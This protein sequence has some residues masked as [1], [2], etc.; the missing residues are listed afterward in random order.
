MTKDFVS[1]MDLMPEIFKL[2]KRDITGFFNVRR[3]Y[4]RGDL[5][6]YHIQTTDSGQKQLLFVDGRYDLAQKYEE[7]TGE[8]V[9]D[10]YRKG[11]R[12]HIKNHAPYVL[13]Q[14]YD[15]PEILEV[16][17]LRHSHHI[18]YITEEYLQVLENLYYQ[19][20]LAFVRSFDPRDTIDTHTY[21]T[22]K[23]SNIIY[24][25]IG[26]R[27]HLFQ[28]DPDDAN[29]AETVKD[30]VC[31]KA[32][33][34]SKVKKTTKS[35]KNKLAYI[36]FP[37]RDLDDLLDYDE[38]YSDTSGRLPSRYGKTFSAL[39]PYLP[40]LIL[41]VAIAQEKQTYIGSSYPEYQ[42][43]VKN[44]PHRISRQTQTLPDDWSIQDELD[45][46]LTLSPDGYLYVVSYGHGVGLSASYHVS[47][48]VEYVDS[49]IN[50]A[51]FTNVLN[52][53]RFMMF[54]TDDV[55]VP[56]DDLPAF[57]NEPWREDAGLRLSLNTS[58]L[59]WSEQDE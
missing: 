40:M 48:R 29:F 41:H 20:V 10:H 24:R 32:E 50:Q 47:G 3:Y 34:L 9:D 7:L 37:S 58:S 49:K 43:L 14:A 26:Q 55:P 54:G 18:E 39:T 38:G 13:G 31:E 23:E 4:S 12:E 6:Q 52:Q 17:Y 15:V 28:L 25:E 1:I 22:D 35:D 46:R 51:I 2:A 59:D 11:R 42:A 33:K 44:L 30:L 57:E 53:I 16:H 21:E 56:I 5:H 36:L 8:K 45:K 27:D 19:Y